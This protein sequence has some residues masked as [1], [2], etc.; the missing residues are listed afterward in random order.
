VSPISAKSLEAPDRSQDFI[1]GSHR[2][3]IVLKTAVIGRGLYRPGWRWS[4]HAGPLKGGSSAAHIG[5]VVSGRL[6]VQDPDGVQTTVG[7]GE[8]FEAPEGHDAWV[9]GDEPC[10][11]LDF[12][13]V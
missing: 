12:G 5:Y 1:D 8:G 2:D 6:V 9:A 7:P 13:A 11:A 10:I 3:V 4:E